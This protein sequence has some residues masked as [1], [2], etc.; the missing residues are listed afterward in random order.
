MPLVDTVEVRAMLG[1]TWIPPDQFDEFRLVRSLGGGAMGQVY[2]AHDTLLDRPVAVKFVRAAA[3]PAARARVLD[4]ARAIARLQHPNVVAI[5]RVAEVAGHPY[6]VS[7]YVQGRALHEL[8]RPLPWRA[9]LDIAIDLARGLAAAHRRGV[10]HRDVKPAN[11]ILTDDGSAKLLDFGLATI[12][13]RGPADEPA[14]C[15]LPAGAR[16]PDP[17]RAP[18]RRDFAALITD[19]TRPMVAAPATSDVVP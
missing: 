8:P 9:V 10:L 2:L 6:L 16:P 13:D 11:A 4:E 17:G 7:E 14:A 15:R 19:P 1:S 18:P 5:Y 12:V 3:D